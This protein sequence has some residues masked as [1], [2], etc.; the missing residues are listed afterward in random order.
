MRYKAQHVIPLPLVEENGGFFGW[1][2]HHLFE[3]GDVPIQA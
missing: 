1:G 3:F 2:P